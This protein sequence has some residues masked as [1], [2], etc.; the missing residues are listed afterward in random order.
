MTG[1]SMH[2]QQRNISAEGGREAENVPLAAR[3][4]GEKLKMPTG[5]CLTLETF[6][7]LWD[8]VAVI[9]KACNLPASKL[10]TAQ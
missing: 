4:E 2:L 5:L 9:P 3:K 6:G 1:R 8:K 7:T 10:Q